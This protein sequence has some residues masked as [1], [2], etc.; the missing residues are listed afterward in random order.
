[1]TK[2]T[3]IQTDIELH[4]CNSISL[5][6]FILCHI[7]KSNFIRKTHIVT[8]YFELGHITSNIFKNTDTHLNLAYMDLHFEPIKMFPM[9]LA[10]FVSVILGIILR[11]EKMMESPTYTLYLDNKEYYRKLNIF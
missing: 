7:I 3:I 1:M 6:Y 5:Y 11:D 4:I 2:D 9:V 8:A 10:Y